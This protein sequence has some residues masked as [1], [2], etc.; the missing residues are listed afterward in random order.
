ML[1]IEVTRVR[2]DC[3]EPNL[4]PKHEVRYTGFDNKIVPMYARGIRIREIQNFL[5]E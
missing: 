5:A 2:A 3:F 1:R 4:F